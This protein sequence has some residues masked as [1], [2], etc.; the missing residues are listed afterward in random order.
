MRWANGLPVKAA[1]R[2][3]TVA[4]HGMNSSEPDGRMLERQQKTPEAGFGKWAAESGGM[5]EA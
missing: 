3:K 2:R 4:G 5:T 1:E